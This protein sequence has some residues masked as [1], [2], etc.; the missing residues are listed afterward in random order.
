MAMK[1]EA[2]P[3]RDNDPGNDR[4]IRFACPGCGS[5]VLGQLTGSYGIRQVVGIAPD[6]E[7]L[8]GFHDIETLE[9]GGCSCW[10][11]GRELEPDVEMGAELCIRRHSG[12]TRM[13]RFLAPTAGGMN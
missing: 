12:E 11:C 10:E 1:K 2:K 3:N 4:L 13:L 5:H 6:G 9:S 7:I 8:Y